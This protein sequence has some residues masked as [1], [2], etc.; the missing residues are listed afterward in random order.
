MKQNLT[1]IILF[2]LIVAVALYFYKNMK[3]NQSAD[4]TV[5]VPPTA[6]DKIIAPSA[7]E[8]PK[9]VAPII[10]YRRSPARPA[11]PTTI[12]RQSTLTNPITAR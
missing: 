12:T 2:G 9:P 7:P 8:A 10:I 11:I 1:S 5:I 4:K 6:G 3:S